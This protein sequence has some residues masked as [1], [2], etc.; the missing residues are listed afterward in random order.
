MCS[1]IFEVLS[2]DDGNPNDLSNPRQN[3]KTAEKQHKQKVSRSLFGYLLIGA[4]IPP[5]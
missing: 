1:V 5:W 3:Q 4:G 2:R